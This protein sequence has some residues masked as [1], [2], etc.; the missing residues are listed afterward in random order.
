MKLLKSIAFILLSSM[1][2]I[3]T[4]NAESDSKQQKKTQ[5]SSQQKNKKDEK[6]SKDDKNKKTE[7]KVEDKNKKTEKKEEDKNKKT[8]KREEDQTLKLFNESVKIKISQANIVADDNN[9]QA[10]QLTY[11]VENKSADNDILALHWVTGF[12]SNKTTFFIQDMPAKFQTV[13]KRGTKLEFIS[14][15]PF[16]EM[17]ENVREIFLSKDAKIDSVIGAKSLTF[18][19]GKKI[20]IK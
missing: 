16:D 13:I 3:S 8:E 18:T 11:L 9:K 14:I 2:A 4:A 5:Q 10:L 6:N 17:P 12:V 19:D 1:L 15:I 7:K 20:D